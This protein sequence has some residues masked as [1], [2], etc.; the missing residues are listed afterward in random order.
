MGP[1]LLNV[2]SPPGAPLGLNKPSGVIRPVWS[3]QLFHQSHQ[4]RNPAAVHLPPPWL[5]DGERVQGRRTGRFSCGDRQT[6]LISGP[7]GRDNSGV[8]PLTTG[9]RQG[10]ESLHGVMPL[11]TSPSGPALAKICSKPGELETVSPLR[12]RPEATPHTN[13][14]RKQT[15]ATKPVCRGTHPR[16]I[17]LPSQPT[18]PKVSI[19]HSGQYFLVCFVWLVSHIPAGRR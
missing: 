5:P 4:K 2:P 10:K 11:P 15:T 8:M 13:W 6:G 18:A 19:P 9:S 1:A 16:C 14:G 3:T 12:Y 17:L 7:H